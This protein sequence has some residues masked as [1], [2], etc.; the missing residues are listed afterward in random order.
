[1]L[2]SKAPSRAIASGLAF[3]LLTACGGGGGGVGG[4]AGITGSSSTGSTSGTGTSASTTPSVPVAPVQAAAIDPTRIPLGDGKLSSTA[5]QV[6]FV[7]VCRIP[8]STNPAGKAPWISADGLTWNS[9]TKVAVQGAV[10][11]VS[12]S[13]ASLLNG[14]F[15][16]VGNGLPS[17]VTG[18][19]P[20][21]P[22]DPAYQ[23]DKNP[24]SIG[25][26]AIA[27]GLPANPTIAT[28]PSCTSLGAIGVLLTGA[29]LF[30]ALDA[31]GRDAAAHEVQDSCEGH[32]QMSGTY[33]YHSLSSCLTQSDTAGTHSPL[34]GY[35]ADGFGLY[36]NLGESGKPLT[37]ADLDECHGHSH[38][39]TINGQ[40][41][42]RYHYHATKEYPYTVGCY[43]GTPA[44][45]H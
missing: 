35:I 43:K 10:S 6:G 20:I 27:W 2:T 32:P 3:C 28:Q 8:S 1:M 34:V 42:T 13:S 16:I 12:S 15:N 41:V 22:Q 4:G 40:V 25:S 17:H 37:N 11:W 38:P 30:N 19:F 33:H 39:I 23:Y 26:V 14:F 5:P 45:I 18:T 24:N 9:T 36:G 7:F 21:S 29:R 31:D 44:N